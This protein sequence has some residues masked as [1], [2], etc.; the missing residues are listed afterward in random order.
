MSVAPDLRPG[1][2]EGD[3]L[4]APD[5]ISLAAPCAPSAARSDQSGRS[6]RPPP[7]RSVWPPPARSLWL[8][9]PRS[10]TPPRYTPM[11]RS[12]R[13]AA[14]L[15]ADG[16]TLIEEGLRSLKNAGEFERAVSHVLSCVGFTSF[17]WGP[18]RAKVAMPGGG[19]TADVLVLSPDDGLVLVVE[20]T[21]EN[22]GTEKVTRLVGRAR[23]IEQQLETE[24]GKSTPVVRAALAVALPMD[25]IAETVRKACDIDAVNLWSGDQLQCAFRDVV[26]GIPEPEVRGALSRYLKQDLSGARRFSLV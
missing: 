14:I 19:A 6:V 20:C 5:A 10:L 26:A 23:R 18:P 8:P 3:Q 4:A 16:R 25:Q 13:V 17:W 21:V 12:P 9:P 11:K 24:L 15:A 22:P 1:F 2:D 7:T